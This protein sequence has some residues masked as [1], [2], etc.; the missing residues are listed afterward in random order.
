MQRTCPLLASIGIALTT[1]GFATLGWVPPAL[2]AA[3]G[4]IA[5]YP[6]PTANSSPVE[7]KT[8]PDGAL[9]FTENAGNKIGRITTSGQITEFALPNANSQPAGI[10]RG[11][12]DNMW[13]TELN[14]NRIGK[15]S[16]DGNGTI[17][18]FTIPT[19]GSQPTIICVGPHGGLWFVEMAGGKVGLISPVDGTIT[20]FP[21]PSAN[22]QPFMFI[23]M[24]LEPFENTGGFAIESDGTIALEFPSPNQ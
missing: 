16:T 7:I 5:E 18:E 4:T 11:P 15:I 6:I 14:G 22:C 24:V 2:A 17:T 12:D 13:F 23:V 21:I 3:P 9:W 8:G 20:E 19:P 1:M 10:I